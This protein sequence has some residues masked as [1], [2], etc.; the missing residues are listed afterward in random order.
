MFKKIFSLIIATIMP[1]SLLACNQKKDGNP[2]A[3]ESEIEVFDNT[4]SP[5]NERIGVTNW[6][7][8]Y[9]PNLKDEEYSL[10]KGA[11]YIRELGS[12]VIKIACGNP[13]T[14]YPLDDFSSLNMTECADAL[15]FPIYKQLFE[16]DFSTYIINIT[17]VNRANYADGMS[18][19]EL[20][21]V[22][23]EFYHATQYLLETYKGTGKTFILQNWETDNY[24]ALSISGNNAE[25]VLRNYAKYYNARQ[26]GINKARNEFV[27]SETKNVFVFGALE[28]NKLSKDYKNRAVDH[29]VPYTYVDLYTYSSYEFK[30]KNVVS[31]AI[32]V[33]EKLTEAMNY[34]KTKLPD[35]TKYPQKA[36]FKDKRL[37]ITEFGYPDKADSNSGNWQKM[38]TEGHVLATK[39]LNLQYAVYWQLCCNEVV[40]D[41]ATAIKGLS[42]TQLRNYNFT[43]ADFNGFY[44]LRPDGT[45]T[46]SYDYL[47]TILNEKN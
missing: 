1:L 7:P 27:M 33:C 34:Y 13:A 37:A 36:Y 25:Y 24:V 45:K 32:E 31:S 9:M 40:G 47:K 38:V 35:Y 17:E 46:L 26:D 15:R 14:Q 28:V 8:R 4:L 19:D 29:V 11:E 10:I 3:P 44:L 5:L 18:N 30:D 43:N 42:K 16:M 41:T 39:N 21:T 12:K 22:E 2:I 6:G 20:K 23:N